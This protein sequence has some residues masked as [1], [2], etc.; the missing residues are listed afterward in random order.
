[1]PKE[2]SQDD[3]EKRK[4]EESLNTLYLYF[5]NWVRNEKRY[6]PHRP[7]WTESY[8]T[9]FPRV[10]LF[11]YLKGSTSDNTRITSHYIAKKSEFWYRCLQMN[12]LPLF[13]TQGERRKKIGLISRDKNRWLFIFQK[14]LTEYANKIG[15][16][17][18][19]ITREYLCSCPRFYTLR[20]EQN[21]SLDVRFFSRWNHKRTSLFFVVLVFLQ[22]ATL[23]KKKT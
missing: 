23:R 16:D 5:E 7:K 8:D 9:D 4:Q 10:W 3:L 18:Q 15:S 21:C 14:K 2:R 11:S 20:R 17:V 12:V 6:C 13:R 19:T 22:T 1:M